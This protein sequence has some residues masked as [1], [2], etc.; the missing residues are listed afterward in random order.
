MQIRTRLTLQFLL[1]GGIIMI[2]A[3]MAIY[4]ASAN[5]RRQDFHNRLIN[6]SL[7]AAKLLLE[8]DDI[9]AGRVQKLERDNP[10]K[11]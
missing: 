11:L 4:Y 3:S 6:N 5:F 2:I 9:D 1:I 8:A 7:I 10:V